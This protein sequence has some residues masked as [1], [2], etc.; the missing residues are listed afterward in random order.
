MRPEQCA[1][2][3]VVGVQ[4]VRL[5]RFGRFPSFVDRDAV[6]GNGVGGKHVGNATWF[7]VAGGSLQRDR[8]SERSVSQFCRDIDGASDDDHGSSRAHRAQDKRYSP[9]WSCRP[10]LNAR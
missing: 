7:V 8:R 5:E 6:G 1:H 4:K 3:D 10:S 2:V 9:G